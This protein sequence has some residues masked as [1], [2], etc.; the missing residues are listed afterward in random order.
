VDGVEIGRPLLETLEPLRAVAQVVANYQPEQI[1][2]SGQHLWEA[3]DA[4]VLPHFVRNDKKASGGRYVIVND[5]VTWRL[6]IPV[7]GTYYVWA[8]I[9]ADD[10]QH[11]SCYVE[12]TPG[13]AGRA[14]HDWHMT[15]GSKWHWDR[16]TFSKSTEP[17]KF[18]L[19]AGVAELTF[20]IREPDSRL[21]QLFITRDPTAPPPG[22]PGFGVDGELNEGLDLEN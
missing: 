5:A 14:R 20:S 19:P 2:E 4:I 21:D 1:P 15:R 7:G 13:S 9:Q 10:P 17:A 16:A 6:R 3:E 18:E 11:D 8:R 12:W 22:H